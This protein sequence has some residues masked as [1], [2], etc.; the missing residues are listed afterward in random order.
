[1]IGNTNAAAEIH[2]FQLNAKGL[3]DLHRS[4][5][6]QTGGVNEGF[7]VQLV[8]DNHAVQPEPFDAALL[9]DFIGL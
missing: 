6:H 5:K 9:G 4:I 8:R 7:G 2:K 1:M 3:I